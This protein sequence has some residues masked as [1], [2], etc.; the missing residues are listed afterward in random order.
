MIREKVFERL[1]EVFRDVFDDEDIILL[2]GMTTS[3][4]E[5]W[6]SLVHITLVSTIE[7]EFDIH[8]GIDQISE[9]KNIGVIVDNILELMK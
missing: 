4:I 5:G 1:N 6:D 8:F 9:M 7:D 3:D 2:D